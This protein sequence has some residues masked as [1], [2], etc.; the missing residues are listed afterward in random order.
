MTEQE[1]NRLIAKKQ[2]ELNG[3]IKECNRSRCAPYIEALLSQLRDSGNVINIICAEELNGDDCRYLGKQIADNFTEIF[4]TFASSG[5]AERKAQRLRKSNA[6]R[7]R[8]Q[9]NSEVKQE[10]IVNF[11]EDITDI[12]PELRQY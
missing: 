3:L 5:I 8:R 9:Q 12:F 11:A 4:Q 6:R 2:K 10:N 1:L 7:A